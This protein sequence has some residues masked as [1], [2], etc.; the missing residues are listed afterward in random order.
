MDANGQRRWLNHSI[1]IRSNPGKAKALQAEL[2]AYRRRLVAEAAL[3][4][5]VFLPL[6]FQM[7]A[8]GQVP[9]YRDISE[10]LSYDVLITGIKSDNQTR[11][12][13][14]KFTESEQSLARVGDETNLYLRADD[15]AGVTSTTGGG[16]MGPFYLP[17]PIL[18]KAGQRMTGEIF[19]TDTTATTEEA[20]IVLIGVRV[21]GDEYA[22]AILDPAERDL[23]ERLISMREIPQPRVLKQLINFETA[24]VGGEKRNAFTPRIEEPLL[25]LG[26]RTNLRQSSIELGI[27][28]EPTWTTKL[29]PIWAVAG[30]DELV[31]DNYQWFSK[32]VYLH[33]ETSIEVRRVVN[34]L[35][36]SNIDDQNNNFLTWICS[37]V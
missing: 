27:Q 4:R 22:N 23:V 31:H 33:S 1:A 9:P 8:A 14:L 36:G 25:L 6:E 13:I 32:P 28:G 24:V 21:F 34:G 26:L 29:T 19:K 16:Q 18:L 11:N 12:V 20:N 7:T 5:P 30:E 17:R 15:I 10:S 37:T 2:D 35:D 3:T